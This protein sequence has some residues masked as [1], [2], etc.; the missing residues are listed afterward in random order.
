MRFIARA[1]GALGIT[2]CLAASALAG[3]L[4]PRLAALTL[5]G[6]A[7][8]KSTAS[9]AVS[10]PHPAN[11]MLPRVRSNGTVQVYIRPLA[12]AALPPRQEIAG[13]GGSDIRVSRT[14]GIIQSWI[15]IGKLHALANLP[16]VGSVTVPA[17]AAP[18]RPF[19]RGLVIGVRTAATAAA[20]LPTGLAIDQSAILAMQAQQLQQVGATGSGIKVGVISDDNSGLSASQTAGYL[21][22]TVWTDP[23]FPGTS[24]TPG[25]PAEGTAML[26]EV[27][28]MAPGASLGF[29]GPQT[30]VD[31]LTCYDDF[32]TWGANVIADD[33]GFPSVDYFTIGETNDQSLAYGAA[34]FAQTHPD[35]AIASSA[36]N[37]AQDYFEAPY[38]AGPGFTVGSTTYASAMD[39]GAA[40]GSSS[41]T[42][43]SVSVSAGAKLTVVLEWNDPLNTS[44]D[45]FQLYLTNS[46]GTI[47]VQG[48]SSTASDGRPLQFLQYTAGSSSEQDS[49]YVGCQ[50]CSNPVTLKLD[51]W[52]NGGAQFGFTTGGSEQGGQ[53]VADGVMATAAAWVL[54]QG[55]LSVNREAFSGRGPFLYG[56]YGAT[57]TVVKP[58]LT[59]IDN[60]L[61]SGAG[62]FGYSQSTGGAL[63]CGTS[64]T[65]PNVGALIAA[66]MQ[67][68][69]GRAA[70]YY[71][72]VLEVTANQTVFA[73]YSSRMGCSAPSSTGYSQ[74]LSGAGLAQGF[75]AL[76][77]FFSFPSTSITK[78]TS[79]PSGT[80]AAVTVPVNVNVTYAAV[81]QSGTNPASAT[82]C[83]WTADSAVT[84]TGATVV[85]VATG[86]GTFSVVSN[87][88]DSNGIL[89][90]TPPRLTVDAQ[91]IAAPTAAISNANMTGFDLT[92]T[93]YEPLTVSGTSS[94]TAIVPNSGISISPSNCGKSTLSCTVTLTPAAKA[95]GTTTITITA[96][97]QWSRSATVK[98]SESYTYTPP[99]SGGGGFGWIA[100]LALGLLAMLSLAG[101]AGDGA[102]APDATSD[103]G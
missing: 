4:D 9:G 12:G 35:V 103:R 72:S 93:G 54:S 99:S 50:A 19:R 28:A 31:F 21:P 82:N 59:G 1:L 64:A 6:R 79:V 81:V 71:Y 58:N 38:T 25:D 70:S 37:D 32:A 2:F 67:A 24:P 11:P 15:P 97:D 77:S 33:L 74:E 43:L 57:S 60:V 42:A 94:N 47:L 8:V 5:G 46:S 66:V 41:N 62:G 73:S 23:S 101:K 63:F 29:C 90:P 30:S 40:S 56:S 86:A 61:V 83:I 44:P 85:Y 20:T 98:Q 14:L 39:F 49:L 96:T 91:N 75:A 89:S 84:Q 17:Y 53:K 102:G 27:H 36:G 100:L 18:P 87:C 76:G 26:E 51:G 68:S 45:V 69:P 80:T 78:P 88:P 13:L 65:S 55:P 92:L 52:A 48:S 7:F 3:R 22:P 95:N 16:G 10:T 34:Q